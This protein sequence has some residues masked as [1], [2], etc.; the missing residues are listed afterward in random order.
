METRLIENPEEIIKRITD[1]TI[2]SSELSVSFAAG[3]MQFNYAYFFDSK[4]KILEKYKKGEHKG[5]RY[6]SSIDSSNLEVTKKFLNVGAHIKHATNLPPMSFGVSDKEMI[7]T[8][9]KMYEGEVVSSIL[10]SN[11]PAYMSHFRAIF[12]ELWNRRCR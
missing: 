2:N 9:D 5:I 12:E 11:D 8:I 4:K 10:V 3:G 6:I 1:F 7:T